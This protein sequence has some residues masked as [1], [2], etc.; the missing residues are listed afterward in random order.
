MW[1][2]GGEGGE[3]GAGGGGREGGA[4]TGALETLVFIAGAR[5]QVK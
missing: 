1:A 4:R 2:V 5:I 3:G